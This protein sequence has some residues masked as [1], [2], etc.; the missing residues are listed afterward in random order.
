M[1]NRVLK[2]GL[3]AVVCALPA[4]LDTSPAHAISWGEKGSNGKVCRVLFGPH[5]HHGRGSG[6]TRSAAKAAAIKRWTGFTSWEYGKAWGNLA[7]AQKKSMS[8]WKAR[9]G[10]WRCKVSA[11]PCKN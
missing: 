1:V 9:R 4:L 3:I 6:A 7:L 11:Q 8:C 10:G 5:N 2:Y